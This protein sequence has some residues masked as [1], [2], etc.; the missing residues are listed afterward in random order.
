MTTV[1]LGMAKCSGQVPSVIA[2]KTDGRQI[3][4]QLISLDVDSLQIETGGKVEKLQ[5]DGLNR[6]QFSNQTGGSEKANVEIRMVDGGQLN[7][8][9]FRIDQGRLEAKLSTGVSLRLNRKHI[10]WVRLANYDGQ[11]EL[12]KQWRNVSQSRYDGD[13]LVVNR[14]GNLDTVE[15]I[16]GDVTAE[17]VAFSIEDRTAEVPLSRIDGIRFFHAGE[18]ELA[19]PRGEL[20]IGDEARIPVL[21][22]VLDGEIFKIVTVCG[23]ELN[24]PIHVPTAINFSMG[25][26]VYLSDLEPTTNDW[27]P[28]VASASLVEVLRTL[29]RAKPNV[30]STGEPLSL[31]FAGDVKKG[32]FPRVTDFE[33][34]FSIGGG[35]KLVFRLNGQFESLLG[36]VGFDPKAN[37]NGK[38]LFK[39]LG[40]GEIL[41]ESKLIRRAMK[42]PIQLDLD[43]S[44]VNR[45]VFQVDYL[46]GR[47]TG[48]QL[49]LA[50]LK[51]SRQ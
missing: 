43:V 18:R 39:V 35:G 37:L 2:S 7:V 47:S 19:R 4:G 6:I 13:A 14:K 10:E 24:V 44:G 49:H 36:W 26:T 40:D 48:D 33:K 38:V 41:L 25:R 29:K 12:L 28:L 30:S 11:M 15:G 16:V 3:E 27:Q 51:V 5:L 50:D 46:D 8:S 23:A 45:I 20:L 31:E 42:N 17:K 34:G 21:R 9:E 22:Y 32:L 1:I